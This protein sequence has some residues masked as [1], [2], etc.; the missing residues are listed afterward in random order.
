MILRV[1]WERARECTV[2][3]VRDRVPVV[4]WLCTDFDKCC[5]LQC[6]Q[7]KPKK[8]CFSLTS[9]IPSW[10]SLSRL[11]SSLETRNVLQ[12][13]FFSSSP[14]WLYIIAPIFHRISFSYLSLCLYFF[15]V[16]FLRINNKTQATQIHRTYK[17]KNSC[18]NCITESLSYHTVTQRVSFMMH[19]NCTL[20]VYV[21]IQFDPYFHSNF[22]FLNAFRLANNKITIWNLKFDP[23]H[24]CYRLNLISG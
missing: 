22:I 21:V 4:N 1:L 13:F 24:I 7:I 6:L 15:L 17:K 14:R 3:C 5:I 16:Q 12:N 19:V 2:N 9:K 8:T 10:E 11:E 18:Y 20:H 23:Q